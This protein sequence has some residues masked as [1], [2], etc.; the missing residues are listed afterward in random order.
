MTQAN[1]VI[2]FTGNGACSFPS[3]HKVEGGGIP[4][5]VKH[6]HPQYE[7][8]EKRQEAIRDT[9]RACAELLRALRSEQTRQIS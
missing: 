5:T 3:A 2:S 7:T 1:N 8:A 9:R 4:M 6:I